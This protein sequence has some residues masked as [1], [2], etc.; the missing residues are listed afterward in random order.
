MTKEQKAILEKQ[1]KH[2]DITEDQ[3]KEVEKALENDTF[4]EITIIDIDDNK[5][6]SNNNNSSNSDSA[7]NNNSNTNFDENQDQIDKIIDEKTQTAKTVKRTLKNEK[8]SEDEN[9]NNSNPFIYVVMVL[10]AV[11]GGLYYLTVR[12][13]GTLPL[14]DSISTENGTETITEEKTETATE[15]ESKGTEQNGFGF[16]G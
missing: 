10:I 4:I 3:K 16:Q 11:F 6:N 13:G 14:T 15:T 8:K 12:N 7:N 2:K 9:V 1:L 5:D